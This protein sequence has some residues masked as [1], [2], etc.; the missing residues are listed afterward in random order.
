L[1]VNVTL[2]FAG[3]LVIVLVTLLPATLTAPHVAPG[4]GNPQLAVTPVMAAGTASLKVV[5]LALLGPWL[6]TTTV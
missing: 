4:V 1:I 5:P 6:V 2:P 3:K